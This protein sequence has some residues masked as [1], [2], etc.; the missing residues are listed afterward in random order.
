MTSTFPQLDLFAPPPSAPLVPPVPVLAQ[1][2]LVDSDYCIVCGLCGPA[3]GTCDACGRQAEE[4]A[5]TTAV[6]IYLH[7]TYCKP[8]RSIGPFDSQAEA[9]AEAHKYGQK[10][11]FDSYPLADNS[12]PGTSRKRTKTEKTKA[13]ESAWHWSPEYPAPLGAIPVPDSIH[14]GDADYSLALLLIAGRIQSAGRRDLIADD[15][16]GVDWRQ[17]MRLVNGLLRG[18]E[19]D[20]PRPTLESLKEIL[21]TRKSHLSQRMEVL[22]GR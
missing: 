16:G 22:S 3:A 9:D 2:A 18:V 11:H 13:K 15:R 20:R 10:H 8:Y 12:A 21:T 5:P 1:S 14:K 4:Y 6:S 19:S 17:V 7:L